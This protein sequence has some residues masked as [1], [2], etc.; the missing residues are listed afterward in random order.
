MRVVGINSENAGAVLI[1][2][3]LPVRSKAG[4]PG[5]EVLGLT[6]EVLT[7][8]LGAIMIFAACKSLGFEL[9]GV[10]FGM[11]TGTELSMM[12]FLM[13]EKNLVVNLTMF[14]IRGVVS[15]DMSSPCSELV[16]KLSKL[17]QNLVQHIKKNV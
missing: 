16:E 4:V 5:G 6:F 8:V 2:C 13:F 1:L 11:E 15:L 17:R 10:K 12:W 9:R 3:F 14:T 7:M